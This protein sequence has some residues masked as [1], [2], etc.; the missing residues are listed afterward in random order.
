[1]EINEIF[2]FNSRFKSAGYFCIVKFKIDIF[3]LFKF[4]LFLVDFNYILN[5]FRLKFIEIFIDFINFFFC[6]YGIFIL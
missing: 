4:I 1:M 3:V 6:L 5:L 2:Y